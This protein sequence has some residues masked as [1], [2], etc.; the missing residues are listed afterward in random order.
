MRTIVCELNL[1]TGC[2]ACMNVC[3]VDAISMQEGELGH[4]FPVI[5][6][7]CIDCNKCEKTCP[8]IHP[9]SLQQPQKVYAA[10]AKNDVEH[11]TSTSGGAASCFSNHVLKQEGTVYGCASLPEGKIE[12]IRIDKLRDIKKL[13]GSKY[14]Q[15]YINNLFRDVKNDLKE[16]KKVLFVGLPCQVAGLKKYLVKD[17][18]HLVTVDMVCH[19]VPSQKIL[20][21]YLAAKGI[22]RKNIKSINFREQQGCYLTVLN[23]ENKS[24]Y[25]KNECAD[26]YY[27]AFNE[28]LCFRNSCFS[29]RYSSPNR[30]GD[31]TIGDFWGLGAKVPFTEKTNGHVSVIMTNN[32]KGELFL[33]E[34]TDQL[35]LVERTLSE[36]VKGNHNLYASSVSTQNTLFKQL[37]GKL[38]LEN[39]LK[40]CTRWR[41][42]KSLFIPA[43]QCIMKRV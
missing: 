11:H 29:C 40:R 12:H 42:F 16:G 30:I 4:I 25:R 19:G 33:Q 9:N 20:F 14:V 38:S 28:N 26:L 24:V 23:N 34:C 5:N 6:D 17:D 37:Y 27:T 1:C 3:L 22:V 41:R 13:K 39:A 36:A 18:E 2:S 32:E 10:W 43:I 35:N 21:D 15:S 8:A 31:I 7:N